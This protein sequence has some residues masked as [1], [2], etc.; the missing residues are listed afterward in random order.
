MQSGSSESLS[1]ITHR[2]QSLSASQSLSATDTRGKHRVLAELKRLEQEA[3]FLEEEL[4]QLEKMEKAS[5][6]CKEMVSNVETR[7]DP[8]LPV[9]N[10]PINP[11]WDRWFEGPQDS[12]GCRCWIL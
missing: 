1:P 2:I 4:E 6:A 11:F 9:T 3:R 10:G 5:A 8:L 12:K 7:P